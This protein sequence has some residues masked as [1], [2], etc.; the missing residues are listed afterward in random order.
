MNGRNYKHKPKKNNC[1]L[2]LNKLLEHILDGTMRK[3]PEVSYLNITF[4]S[5][6][7]ILPVLYRTLLPFLQDEDR[8][9]PRGGRKKEGK[10]GY[11]WKHKVVALEERESP[12]LLLKVTLGTD[13]EL[14]VSIYVWFV[15]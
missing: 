1:L 4:K 13:I 14:K 15:K 3:S 2:L 6:F 12:V 5:S 7:I 10:I 9:I 8:E 11:F